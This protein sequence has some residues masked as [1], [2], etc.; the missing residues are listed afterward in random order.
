LAKEILN[1]KEF[2]ALEL[3]DGMGRKAPEALIPPHGFDFVPAALRI[4]IGNQGTLALK[5]WVPGKLA[6]GSR[7]VFN[8]GDPSAIGLLTERTT[9]EAGRA[10]KDGVV[11]V[12]VHIEGRARTTGPVI[13]T[14][15]AGPLRAEARVRVDDPQEGRETTSPGS[16]KQ[17]PWIT[18][19]E[20]AVDDG[21]ARHSRYVSRKVQINTRTQTI[22]RGPR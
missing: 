18:Y 22:K 21:P 8:V 14:A 20:M 12:H 9:L 7:V 11:T 1:A 2:R 10:N 5:A 17:G 15:R 13:L 4:G 6:D 19:E 3:L 16:E